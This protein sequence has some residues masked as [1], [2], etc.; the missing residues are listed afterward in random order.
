V[1]RLA[2][3][4]GQAL[5]LM[6]L[7]LT[8]LLGMAAVCVDVGSWY[9]ADRQAQAAAD[10][11]ALAAAQ[12]LPYDPTTAED[13]AERYADENGGGL[14]T[15]AFGTTG[16]ADS[17]TVTVEIERAAPS[18]FSKVLGMDSVTVG[19]KAS[20]RAAGIGKARWVAPIVVSEK[21]EKLVC[22]LGC[23]GPGHQTELDYYHLAS[24]GDGKGSKDH[25]NDPDDG[26][27]DGGSGSFGFINLD[28]SSTNGVGTS[29]LGDWLRHGYDQYI[30]P[31]SYNTSTGNPFSSSHVSG[32]LADRIGDVL[33]FPVYESLAGS[34]S[35]ARYEIVA[36]VGFH[37]TGTKLTG[38]DEKLFGYFTEIIWDGIEGGSPS[39]PDYGARSVA[40][41]E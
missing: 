39:S 1:N 2:D 23:F 28:A 3:Q 41:V 22:G 37:L 31:G 6:S 4:T 36:F 27:V 18:F 15:V 38:N 10:A 19:A 7:F 29:T 13:H 5:I 20:A 33:L 16:P 34:G 17:D 9:H 8:V 24:G 11:A 21:H 40:L 25:E 26:S 35:N 30:E 14:K 32:A 12:A